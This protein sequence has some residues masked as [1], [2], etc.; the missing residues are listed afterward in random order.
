MKI[1]RVRYSVCVIATVL[2]VS[3]LCQPVFLLVATAQKRNPKSSTPKMSED[4]RIA[5]VL[6]RLTFGARPGDFERVKAMGIDAFIS[7]QLDSD[8]YD[9]SAAVAKLR[10]LQTLRMATPT[11]IDQYTPPKPTPTPVPVKLADNMAAPSAN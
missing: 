11:I 6:S 5:H 7:L 8:S 1:A 10:G 9:D 3:L 4:Q 2:A